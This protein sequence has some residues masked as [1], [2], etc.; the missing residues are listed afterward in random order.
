M[1]ETISLRSDVAARCLNMRKSCHRD[2]IEVAADP[3]PQ[4]L[5]S[6]PPRRTCDS[7]VFLCEPEIGDQSHAKS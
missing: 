1:A 6:R 4:L 7:T 2:C 3:K 5:R